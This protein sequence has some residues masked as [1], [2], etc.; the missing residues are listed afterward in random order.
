MVLA[1]VASHGS[2]GGLRLHDGAIRGGEHAGHQSKRPKALCHSVRLHVTVVVLGGPDIAALPL[3]S[4]RH[5]VI[6]QAVLIG[7]ARF[8]KSIL[9]L[10][11]EDLLE[12][13]LEATV[14]GLQDGVLGRE[15]HR[16]SAIQTVVQRRP[17]E[18]A[19]RGV[20]VV[21]RHGHSAAGGVEDLKTLGFAAV[22]RL[23]TNGEGSWS[24][25]DKVCG[26]VLVT[27]GVAADDDGLVPARNK[28]GNIRNDDGLAK[29]DAT[30]NVANS[31]IGASPHLLQTELFNPCLIGGDGRALDPDAVFLDGVGCI[32]GDL[33]VGLI[34]L[35]D[36]QVVILKG[37]VEVGVNEAVLDE[38]PNNS[39]HFVAV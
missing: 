38:L 2:M 37:D 39:R 30:E 22:F 29:D 1:V 14:I 4:R 23:E 15:I 5:H 3:E 36:P 34:A 7:D 32:N 8:L 16:V 18:V 21:H 12:D 20:E 19:D 28:P 11:L 27:K 10:R 25:K 6:N 26:A 33:I 9:E 24:V 35:L 13:V 17:S 31:P